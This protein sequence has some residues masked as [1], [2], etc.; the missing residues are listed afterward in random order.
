[1]G[2]NL[3]KVVDICIHVIDSLCYRAETNTTLQVNYTPAKTNLKNKN[4][5]SP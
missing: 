2:K 4:K 1:M 5:R 3:K